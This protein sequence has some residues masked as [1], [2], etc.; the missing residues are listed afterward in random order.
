M[1]FFPLIQK[2]LALD[3]VPKPPPNHPEVHTGLPLNGTSRRL[4]K[5]LEL[6]ELE[7]IFLQRAHRAAPGFYRGRASANL[8]EPHRGITT[9]STDQGLRAP[10]QS[11]CAYMLT[12]SFCLQH[13]SEP[14]IH[15]TL[16]CIL[17]IQQPPYKPASAALAPPSYYLNKLSIHEAM[18]TGPCSPAPGKTKGQ[19]RFLVRQ[20]QY[21]EYNSFPRGRTKPDKTELWCSSTEDT[22]FS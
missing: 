9:G 4:A 15:T 16:T 21:L 11:Y 22:N 14:G 10:G 18:S 19:D 17:T 20:Q 12:S 6:T 13:Q 7:S 8:P 2:P 1:L 5:L 3:I